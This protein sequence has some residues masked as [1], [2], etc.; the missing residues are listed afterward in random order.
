MSSETIPS[1]SSLDSSCR[2]LTISSSLEQAVNFI[3]RLR[4]LDN[5]SKSPVLGTDLPRDDEEALGKSATIPWTLSNKYYQ[6]DV[7]FHAREVKGLA[8]YHSLNV[9]A[10]IFVWSN[11]DSY[12]D[13]VV[14]IA[15]DISTRQPDVAL[16]VRMPRSSSGNEISTEVEED[17]EIDEFLSSHGFEFIDGEVE[18]QRSDRTEDEGLP[19]HG[20]P[21][22]PRVIDSLSTIMWP[23]MS[24]RVPTKP[25]FNRQ[26]LSLFSRKSSKLDSLRLHKEAEDLV[27][28]LE[29]DPAFRDIVKNDPW[30]SVSEPGTVSTSP[31]SLDPPLAP[32]SLP[33]RAGP[34]SILAFDDDFADFV[35]APR[36]PSSGRTTPHAQSPTSATRS[37]TL[38]EDGLR[39]P[40]SSTLYR[41]LGSAAN[42]AASQEDEISDAKQ[43]ETSDDDDDD[44][45]SQQEIAVTAARIFGTDIPRSSAIHAD[46][47]AD[48][49]PVHPTSSLFAV[50]SMSS[51]DP[52]SMQVVDLYDVGQFD[53]SRVLDALR[54]MKAEIASMSD[55]GERRRAAARVALGLVYGLEG[56][57]ADDA[58]MYT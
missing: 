53:L 25:K 54:G 55:E 10:V 57:S 23:S 51:Q 37:G 4:I 45:P 40:F 16:A 44:L 42:L 28:W 39:S 13:H 31:T 17:G 11:G 3:D 29:D 14:R 6:A 58:A 5:G 47:S 33:S 36:E 56:E 21:G 24:T 7:H 9:P 38:D 22:L 46:A 52:T 20:I 30:K 26:R 1:S 43:T 2:I 18:Y 32:W 35:S 50:D 41:A 34:P 12:R 48:A 49:S 15:N 19:D 27:R 8:P